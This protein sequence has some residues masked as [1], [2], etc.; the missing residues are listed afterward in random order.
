[1]RANM[2]RWIHG[3]GLLFAVMLCA[4]L[5]HTPTAN[6]SPTIGG[7]QDSSLSQS[8]EKK[9]KK[10]SLKWQPPDVDV[11]LA[12]LSAAPPCQLPQ[13]LGRAG[14]RVTAMIANLQNFTASEN[15][16]YQHVDNLNGL[17][18]GGNAAYDYFVGF[19]QGVGISIQET[20][21]PAKGHDFIGHSFAR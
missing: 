10:R 19:T 3:T 5:A 9:P 15:I 18:D 13:V 17:M 8:T 14:A 12:S 2:Q 21:T 6:S 4:V 20:R 1:M 16:E 11:R 7:R